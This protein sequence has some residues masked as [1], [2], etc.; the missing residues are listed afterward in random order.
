MKSIDSMAMEMAWSHSPWGM[1]AI[2]RNGSVC[3]VSPAFESRTG[4]P[5]SSLIGMSEADFI[6]QLD[7]PMIDHRRV[8]M[9][10]GGVRAI[11]YV[12]SRLTS[13]EFDMKQIAEKLRAPLA[14][15]YGFSELLLTQNYDEDVRRNLTVTIIEQVE[16]M[17]SVINEELDLNNHASATDKAV[18]SS[19]STLSRMEK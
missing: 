13:R 9:A 3:S 8:E 2:D 6:F 1:V 11:H 15:I 19:M 5:R 17:V 14:S 10:S 18:G 16:G 4:I 7:M 12:N